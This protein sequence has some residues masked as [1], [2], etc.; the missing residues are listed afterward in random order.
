MAGPKRRKRSRSVSDRRFIGGS[1]YFGADEAR[2]TNGG[3]FGDDRR[4]AYTENSQGQRPGNGNWPPINAWDLTQTENS[5]GQRPGNGRNGQA[6][7]GVGTV[8]DWL[9]GLDETLTGLAQR[10]AT[11]SPAGPVRPAMQPMPTFSPGESPNYITN[12]PSLNLP[13]APKYNFK[14]NDFTGQANKM[15]RDAYAPQYAALE[16]QRG[17]A[18]ASYDRSDQIIEGLYANLAADNK[19]QITGDTARYSRAETKAGS[20]GADLEADI[21][22]T[23]NKSAAKEAALMRSL[24]VQA[25]APDVFKEGTADRNYYTTQAKRST[26]DQQDYLQ[27]AGEGQVDYGQNL[28]AADRT[29]GKV[30]R[31]ALLTALTST[32]GELD[33]EES[34]VTSQQSQQALSIAESLA[35]QDLQLQQQNYGVLRDQYGD[36]VNAAQAEYQSALTNANLANQAYEREQQAQA[37][38]QNAELEAWKMQYSMDQDQ[39]DRDFQNMQLGLQNGQWSAEHELNLNKYR[40]ALAT[41]MNNARLQE[42]Q[43]TGESQG[44][45]G[46]EFDDQSKYSQVAAQGLAAGGNQQQV[47]VVMQLADTMATN[48]QQGEAGHTASKPTFVEGLVASATQQ[49]IPPQLAR[50]IAIQY[51][52]RLLAGG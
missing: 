38:Q 32:L 23:Y 43:I 28:A 35:N 12:V 14:R 1:G 10:L 51:W 50:A 21:A 45:S 30:D 31:E 22:D 52:D 15:A 18:K 16:R 41:E 25:A 4:I 42:M 47:S 13:G 6:I 44:N 3:Y 34:G 8:T 2:G 11:A 5:Q 49:G 19:E 40:T 48:S 9:A 27:S 36:S 24:G 46:L 33:N 7:P 29:Q 37:A 39:Q 20:R 26:K 17:G